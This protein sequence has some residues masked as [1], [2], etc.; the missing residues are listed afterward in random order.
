[1]GVTE[2]FLTLLTITSLI[3]GG[4]IAVSRLL[5]VVSKQWQKASDNLLYLGDEI[6]DLVLHKEKEHER[7]EERDKRLEDRFERHEQWHA[8]R[9]Q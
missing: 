4:I 9:N 7:L 3:L 5:W 8:N 6:K 2:R 1:M